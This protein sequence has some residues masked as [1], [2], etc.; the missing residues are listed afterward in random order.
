MMRDGPDHAVTHCEL[1]TN[2]FAALMQ[3]KSKG[4]VMKRMNTC[5][6][7]Q[8]CLSRGSVSSI[9]MPSK[10]K[11]RRCISLDGRPSKVTW[12]T[13]VEDS[14]DTTRRAPAE[15][16]ENNSGELGSS[17]V[18]KGEI[19]Y[20]KDDYK[21]MLME[22]WLT[23]R[24]MRSL[25]SLSGEEVA[26][27]YSDEDDCDNCRFDELIKKHLIDPEEYCERGLESY[28]S[29]E[30]RNKINV[31]RKL[32]RLQVIE[33]YVR[34]GVLG[35]LNPELVRSVSLTQSN[36]SLIRSQKIALV[37][38]RIERASINTKSDDD[39]KHDTPKK[40]HTDITSIETKMTPL[41]RLWSGSNHQCK[42]KT[43]SPSPPTIGMMMVKDINTKLCND[44]RHDPF[45]R[46]QRKEIHT[47]SGAIQDTAMEQHLLHLLLRQEQ[48][49]R[50][51]SQYQPQHR[52]PNSITI[53]DALSTAINAQT[54]N[55]ILASLQ[56]QEQEQ[57]AHQKHQQ[58]QQRQQEQHQQ[59][60]N[61]RNYQ[62]QVQRLFMLQQYQEQ[63]ESMQLA[64]A[65]SLGQWRR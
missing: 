46:M 61:Q 27:E 37:D 23:V 20:S 18:A 16:S 56:I 19:W 52:N 28:L 64:S 47:T 2:D 1:P 43:D 38:Q 24:I 58:E 63:Y 31:T 51:Q 14:S 29:E 48:N 21:Q 11:M 32:H 12:K 39:E 40:Y 22:Q 50:A 54:M 7:I 42:N 10:K 35:R 17:P 4:I 30:R 59:L 25:R 45:D 49:Q 15:Y 13:A 55:S 60:Q 36:K 33:E 62:E 57:L 34:Q 53:Q 65:S 8:S 44:F 3:T 6:G 26:T 41:D 9:V 5:I